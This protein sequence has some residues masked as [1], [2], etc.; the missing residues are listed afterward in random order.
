MFLCSCFP[1]HSFSLCHTNSF[2]TL[3]LVYLQIISYTLYYI[4]LLAENISSFPVMTP[5]RQFN[6]VSCYLFILI[7][8]LTGKIDSQKLPQ[9]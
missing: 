2:V 6:L 5:G 8:Y 7:C 9:N 3:L 1:C 4:T